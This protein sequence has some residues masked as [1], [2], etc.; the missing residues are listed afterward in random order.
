MVDS[1]TNPVPRGAA[2]TPRLTV[3]IPT[4]CRSSRRRLLQDAVRS[5]VD[6]QGVAFELLVVANGPDI[7]AALLASII[8]IAEVT[9][10]QL[11]Q[12]NVSHARLAGVK[13]SS[14]DYFCFLDDDDELLPGALQ[15]RVAYLDEHPEV[16]F[17][18]TDGIVRSANRERRAL[19]DGM[20]AAIRA[21]PEAAFLVRNWFDSPSPTFRRSTIGIEFLSSDLRYYEWTWMLLALLGRGRRVAVL[22]EATFLKR[23]NLPDSISKSTD[24]LL[25]LPAFLR[26]VKHQPLSAQLRRGIQDK[27]AAACHDCADHYL[28]E[29]KVLDALRWHVASLRAGGWRYAP[30]FGHI[31]AAALRRTSS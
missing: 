10:L 14:S 27:L 24:F 5:V 2:A 17:L 25:A 6:Q 23:D 30:F 12:G 15:Q 20:A 16:D 26:A 31:F 11:P 1:P 22:E 13:A 7:D 29:G 9:V 4:S 3:I 19:R 18:V 21:D 8:G 28:R